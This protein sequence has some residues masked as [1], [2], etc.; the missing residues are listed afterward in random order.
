MSQAGFEFRRADY[1][2]TFYVSQFS[3][4]EMYKVSNTAIRQFQDTKL[5]AQAAKV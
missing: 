3:Y 1:L 5:K 2:G 4:S